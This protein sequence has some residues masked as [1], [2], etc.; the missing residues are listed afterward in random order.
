MPMRE[1][2]DKLLHVLFARSERLYRDKSGVVA[3]LFALALLPVLLMLGAAVDYTRASSMKA[4]LQD[5]V[6]SAA[7][8]AAA[9]ASL[10]QAQR[11]SLAQSTVLLNLGTSASA[12]N[13]TITETETSGDYTVTVTAAVPT[14]FMTIAHINSVPIAAAATATNTGASTSSSSSNVCILALSKTISPGFLVNSGVSITAPTCEIDVASTGNPAATFNASAT[15]G[16][17]KI[18]VAGTHTIQNGGAV[19]KLSTGCTTAS[20]PF[21][22]SLPTPTVG[23]CA[24]SNENYS[25]NVTLSPGVYCG[26]FNFNSPASTVTF[27]PGLYILKGASWNMNSGWEMTGTGVTF[28]FADSSYIQI[29]SGVTVNLT[30]PTTGTYANILM[31]EAPG[32]SESAFTINGSAGHT[33]AG[34]IHLP[35]RDI[36]FNSMSNVSAEALT[37][38]VNSLILDTDS[39]NI[40]SSPYVIPSAGAAAT[41][42]VVL[43]R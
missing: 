34:L 27:N 1:R 33:F 17:A 12:L 40:K 42:S 21:A 26:N 13:P 23:S 37:V 35:S 39:W 24:V 41:T 14:A 18:C 19:S 3:I 36:T 29:N 11:L 8:N 32:L 31:F 30:A 28:Y 7:L 10:T 5:A 4:R 15:F 38:V 25:G 43:T 6:D 16:V 20:D 2:A 22:S 9:H